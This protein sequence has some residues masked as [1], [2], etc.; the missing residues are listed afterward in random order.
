MDLSDY[1][2]EIA[3]RKAGSSSSSSK[4]NARNNIAQSSFDPKRRDWLKRR[5]AEIMAELQRQELTVR[6]QRLEWEYG[7]RYGIHSSCGSNI[8]SRRFGPEPTYAS[9]SGPTTTAAAG[10]WANYPTTS[11]QAACSSSSGSQDY[12]SS[13]LSASDLAMLRIDDLREL[14]RHLGVQLPREPTKEPLINALVTRGVSL[15]N[16]SHGK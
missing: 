4:L 8:L 2:T 10:D 14:M 16:L 13:K 1:L 5:L 9:V 15:K 12:S 7:H 6:M 3:R 11:T